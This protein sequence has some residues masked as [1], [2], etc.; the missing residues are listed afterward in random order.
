[1][2][3]S[4]CQNL[5]MVCKNLN[6]YLLIPEGCFFRG[7]QFNS[8][9]IKELSE[10]YLILPEWILKEMPGR[11]LFIDEFRMCKNLVS[12]SDLNEYFSSLEMQVPE[13]IK[14]NMNSFGPNYPAFPISIELADEYTLWL[15]KN[16]LINFY[17]PSE[18][19][20]EKAAKGESGYEYPWGDFEDGP[21]NIKTTGPNIPDFSKKYIN[22]SPF[23]ILNMGG[24]IE[25]I[26][27]SFNSSYE[28]LNIHIPKILKYR[29]LKG[30]TCEHNLDLARCSRRHGKIPSI[31]TGLRLIIKNRECKKVKDAFEID[32]K[33]NNASFGIVKEYYNNLIIIDF[34]EGRY[35][36]CDINKLC[37]FDKFLLTKKPKI[38]SEILVKIEGQIKDNFYSCTRYSILEFENLFLQ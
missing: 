18:E 9:R 15:R 12:F 34:G 1:M 38:G 30:G 31:Y 32:F 25:E 29:I 22:I 13:N 24:N 35:G 36:E 27:S 19:E 4:F 26:T 28:G 20:W 5:N 7:T 8:N 33:I 11:D 14:L 16:T 2:L 3:K 37:D 6:D 17:L 10:K 21:V 23:G